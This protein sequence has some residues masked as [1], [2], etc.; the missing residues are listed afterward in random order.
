[1]RSLNEHHQTRFY[2]FFAA[3]LSAT[4]GIAFSANLF[5]LFLF[6][7]ILTLCT[8]PLAI[9]K[10]AQESLRAG[11]RYLTYLLGTSIAFQLSAIFLTYHVA[12][13]LQFSSHGILAGRGPDILLTVLFILFIAGVTKAAMMPWT[14]TAFAI[15]ALS[16]I[17]VP[18]L[19][20]FISKWY[21][22]SG[23]I[24]A[25]ALPILLV[26]LTSSLLNA[27]YFLPILYK[28]FFEAPH[29]GPGPHQEAPPIHEAPALI[30]VPLL[31]TAAIALG[32]GLYPDVLLALVRQV[33]P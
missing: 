15:G 14:M 1:M 19:A 26:L 12:G 10:Q 32:L 7:E 24:E 29:E 28:A 30:V 5:I 17:G 18:P 11:R 3:A 31:L 23:A 21:L 9:H 4:M 13:T 20:G 22:V 2:I 33:L 16:L 25:N 8:Y 27:G 6:Y